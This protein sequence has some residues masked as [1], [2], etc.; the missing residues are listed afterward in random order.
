MKWSELPEAAKRYIIYHVLV[1]PLL[2]SWYM[3]PYD[4]LSGGYEVVE[5]GVLFTAV[6]VLSVPAKV[7]LGRY[8]SFHD[9]KKGLFVIDLLESTSFFILYMASG[10]TAALLVG[11]ALLI[12]SIS[13]TFY[14]LYQAYERAVYPEDRMKEALVWHLALPD[15]AIL[16]SYPVL[17]YIFGFLCTTNQCIRYGFLAF[18]VVDALLAVYI[19][20][21]FHP[22]VLKK[23]EE[24]ESFL[25]DLKSLS[26]ILRGK[27]KLFFLT[28]LLYL[29]A[30]RFMPAFV[31][32]NYIVEEYSGNLFHVALLEASI[33]LAT[34]VSMFVVNRIPE[35]HGFATMIL[36]TIGVSTTTLIFFLKP[37]FSVLLLLGFLLRFFDS[38]WFVFNRN[39]LYKTITREEAALV[40]TGISAISSTVFMFTPLFS[41]AL[42]QISPSLPYLMGF[43]LMS[44]TIPLL[45]KA[46]RNVK[47]GN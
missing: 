31:L 12:S 18:G 10:S 3:V 37:P 39:W 46:S 22:V 21:Y 13:E 2:F 29:L 42:A 36:A 33:S 25:E 14:P 23:E 16:V 41:G 44:S 27:L 6:N 9:V 15:A 32:V 8:F 24:K 26:K 4:L 43:I 28:N 7:M 34:L 17:G 19:Y 20:M 5:L 45:I 38:A 11:L 30:W 1:S 35:R 40:S 47:K